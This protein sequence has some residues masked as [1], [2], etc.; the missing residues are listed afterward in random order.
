MERKRNSYG[1]T[2][3]HLNSHI[4]LAFPL[5]IPHS[6]LS[7]SS[8]DLPKNHETPASTINKSTLAKFSE[9]HQPQ[10]LK[11]C[12]WNYLESLPVSDLISIV[13]VTG[14]P[15]GKLLLAMYNVTFPWKG[16]SEERNGA[17]GI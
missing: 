3:P 4:K 6:F 7:L 13:D 2:M 12:R 9:Q 10:C 14:I 5:P 16:V 15:K 8:S 11:A 1:R 17:T